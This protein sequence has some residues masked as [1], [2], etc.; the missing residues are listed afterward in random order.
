MLRLS[1]V[2]PRDIPLNRATRLRVTSQDSWGRSVFDESDGSSPGW[3]V[4]QLH[5][6]DVESSS[7]SRKGRVVKSLY[8]GRISEASR[9]VVSNRTW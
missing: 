5:L 2:L 4:S 8:P 6:G 9:T 7:S 1:S 3:H